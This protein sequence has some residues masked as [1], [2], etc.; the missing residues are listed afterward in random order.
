NTPVIINE[1]VLTGHDDFANVDVRV[2]KASLNT[3]LNNDPTFPP[4]GAIVVE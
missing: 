2:N 4:S 1:A 3:I